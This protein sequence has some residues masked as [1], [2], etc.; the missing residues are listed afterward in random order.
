MVC[1]P[2]FLRAG[3]AGFITPINSVARIAVGRRSFLRWPTLASIGN[4]G[5]KYPAA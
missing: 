2:D 4:R 1:S 3:W 5:G